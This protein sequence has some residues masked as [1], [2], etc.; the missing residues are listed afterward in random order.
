MPQR[1]KSFEYVPVY[2]GDEGL[3]LP[4]QEN[5]SQ[6]FVEGDL[7][8]CEAEGDI[9]LATASGANEILGIALADATNTAVAA[10]TTQIPV[11]IIRRTDLYKANY[12]IAETFVIADIGEI[13][14]I[15]RTAA[16]NWEVAAAET[17]ADARVKIIG[18]TES[19]FEQGLA[20][21]AGGGLYVRFLR[22]DGTPDEIL[23]Y[24]SDDAF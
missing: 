14:L 11:R 17:A 12:V 19:D 6:S 9:S 5:L 2:G 20:A 10:D 7:V 21:T 3:V 13:H 1:I 4:F 15:V 16:G 22:V 8:F 18:T 23:Q 24:E